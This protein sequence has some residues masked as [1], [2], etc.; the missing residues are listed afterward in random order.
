MS[1]RLIKPSI[2]GQNFRENCLAYLDIRGVGIGWASITKYINLHKEQ[3]H[4][5]IRFDRL[6][7]EGD[8]GRRVIRLDRPYSNYGYLR[9]PVR[10]V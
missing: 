3:I 1:I 7:K 4:L 2:C 9:R 5:G 10:G 8:V 6:E